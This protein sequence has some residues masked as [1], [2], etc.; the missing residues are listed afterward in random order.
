MKCILAPINTRPAGG[1]GGFL[2]CMGSED[3]PPPQ[4]TTMYENVQVK[5]NGPGNKRQGC[6]KVVK[7]RG[8]NISDYVLLVVL[9]TSREVWGHAPQKIF[10]VFLCSETAFSTI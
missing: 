1:G 2:A 5:K 7:S 4:A 8:G 6:R 3:P 9:Y 10:L